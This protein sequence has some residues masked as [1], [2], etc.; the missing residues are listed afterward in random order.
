MLEEASTTHNRKDNGTVSLVA[1]LTPH[2]MPAYRGAIG[3]PGETPRA[4]GVTVDPM[5]L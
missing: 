2:Q 3:A 5:Q 1:P 4:L